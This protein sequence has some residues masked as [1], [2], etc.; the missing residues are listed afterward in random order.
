MRKVMS[1]TDDANKRLNY[2]FK[3]VFQPGHA[4]ARKG[5]VINLLNRKFLVSLQTD[6]TQP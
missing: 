2:P 5:P 4:L 6:V 3:W 1:L